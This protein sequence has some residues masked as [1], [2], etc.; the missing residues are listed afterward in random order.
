MRVLVR[1]TVANL[2]EVFRAAGGEEK[3][4]KKRE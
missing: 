1:F 4:E 2:G 3:D